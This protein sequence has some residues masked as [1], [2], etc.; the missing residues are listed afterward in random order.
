MFKNMGYKFEI[1]ESQIETNDITKVLKID[2]SNAVLVDDN[3]DTM[4]KIVAK[5]MS[6]DENIFDTFNKIAAHCNTP[7]ELAFA[8]Y[9]YGRDVQRIESDQM[10]CM[11]MS[12]LRAAREARE[13]KAEP[14]VETANETHA[15]AATEIEAEPFAE[16][17]AEHAPTPNE[18]GQHNPDGDQDNAGPGH[19]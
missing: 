3:D 5:S 15:E 11:M 1:D 4:S 16:A 12:A 17:T 7:Q 10:A 14:I 18:P 6:N 13:E 2:Q 9:M 19:A 8:F